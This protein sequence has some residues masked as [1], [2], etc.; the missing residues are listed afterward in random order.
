MTICKARVAL[1]QYS[2]HRNRA[3]SRLILVVLFAAVL[4]VPVLAQSEEESPV[5][6]G[7]VT[8][9]Q[10]MWRIAND[11]RPEPRISIPQYMLAIVERNPDAFIA[12]NVNLLREGAILQMPTTE[13]A[14]AIPADEA[15]Q[16]LDE[17]MA[18]FAELS[19]EERMSLR[20]TAETDPLPGVQELDSLVDLEEVALEPEPA[21]EAE[22][23]IAPVEEL[24]EPEPAPVEPDPAPE[25]LDVVPEPEPER[26][27]EVAI[28]DDVPEPE[29]VT[30]PI[31]EPEPASPEI[32]PDPPEE[33][34]D[35]LPEPDP[36]P[37]RPDETL[38]DDPVRVPA[39]P[40]VEEE[41]PEETVPPVTPGPGPEPAD[42][43]AW[44]VWGGIAIA[45]L[46][47]VLVILGLYKRRRESA[48]LDDYPPD[49]DPTPGDDG[50]PPQSPGGG[51]TA[52]AMAGNRSESGEDEVRPA[53]DD[54][55]GQDRKSAED[56]DDSSWASLEES[57]LNDEPD[58]EA[59]TAVIDG[60]HPAEQVDDERLDDSELASGAEPDPMP[61]AHEPEK[62]PAEDEDDVFD[63]AEWTEDRREHSAADADEDEQE[64]DWLQLDDEA[65]EA[66]S[67][68]RRDSDGAAVQEDASESSDK[69]T[70]GDDADVESS[71]DL[72]EEF[73]L[74]EF[75]SSAG[76]SGEPEPPKQQ[77]EESEDES[78]F[79]LTNFDFD[80]TV[81]GEDDRT[82]VQADGPADEQADEPVP[83]RPSRGL[84]DLDEIMAR[85][86]QS[87]G[88]LGDD[89]DDKRTEIAP[90]VD[91]ADEPDGDAAAEDETV[92]AHS[93][94][95]TEP[96]LDDQEAEVMI[97]LARLTAEGGDEPY[98]R[99]LLAEVIRDGSETM[100]AQARNVLASFR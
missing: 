90:P 85:D 84:E 23:E 92:Q 100:A 66:P 42:P 72:D 6:I 63:L 34:V 52:G 51:S 86:L 71:A 15:Q 67:E 29:P 87:T 74:S 70:A 91:P 24:P 65:S 59:P 28:V 41:A 17:Q 48:M 78:V 36:Q 69:A 99:E 5:T 97:D 20:D 46:M 16:L 21:P 89:E 57:V 38:V 13:E 93:T 77:T 88:L 62:E 45:L 12:G 43:L 25:P 4:V 79:D 11:N 98:A 82:V 75:S 61:K 80:D 68:L 2:D 10:T 22:Q 95:E 60:P 76:E 32:V 56:E 30:D 19:R 31:D 50:S 39:E 44:W 53:P 27:T 54:D 9:D 37:E 18:W 7:P 96:E 14:L 81:V 94:S 40:A 47:V 35:P 3:C 8:A 49:D 83:E 58:V 33:R 55:A 26:D 64:F 1:Q 73:D